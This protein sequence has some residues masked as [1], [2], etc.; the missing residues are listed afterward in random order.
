MMGPCH[1]PRWTPY[2]VFHFL[3]TSVLLQN[4][5]SVQ[6]D[7]IFTCTHAQATLDWVA[8]TPEVRPIAQ[9]L[10]AAMPGRKSLELTDILE[11]PIRGT[12]LK[13]S[14]TWGPVS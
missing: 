11:Q 10:D 8:L 1:S 7:I 5:E 13:T 9:T 6:G 14:V 2:S 3:C 12:F 4:M